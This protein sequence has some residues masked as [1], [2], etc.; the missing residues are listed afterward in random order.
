MAHSLACPPILQNCFSVQGRPVL[1]SS[2]GGRA[3]ASVRCDCWDEEEGNWSLPRLLGSWAAR[4]GATTHASCG[5]PRG[6]PQLACA[7]RNIRVSVRDQRCRT[8]V[9]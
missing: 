7:T 4:R 5:P 9:V 8:P 3:P 1:A 2:S 6:G